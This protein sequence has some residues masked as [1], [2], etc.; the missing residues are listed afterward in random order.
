LLTLRMW[1]TGRRPLRVRLLLLLLLHLPLR[2]RVPSIL[3]LRWMGLPT[4]PLRVDLRPLEGLRGWGTG[5]LWCP[6]LTPRM[7][8]PLLTLALRG[9]GSMWE[10]RALLADLRLSVWLTLP[11]SLAL[12][13]HVLLLMVRPLLWVALSL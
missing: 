1:L 9:R 11:L 12:T 5:D 8:L 13:L 7:G 2:V 4:R 3:H 6:L 10:G